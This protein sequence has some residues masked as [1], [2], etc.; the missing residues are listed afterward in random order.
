MMGL[1]WGFRNCKAIPY[2][3]Q[4]IPYGEQA[5]PW[6]CHQDGQ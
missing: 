4:A 5:W 2:G 6:G 3:E 1:A